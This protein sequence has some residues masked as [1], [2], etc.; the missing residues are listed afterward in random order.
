L[1]LAD[2]RFLADANVDPEVVLALSNRGVD[3]V[4]MLDIGPADFP[5]E[6]VLRLAT[7][8][9]RVLITHD[10][11]FGELTVAQGEPFMGIVFLRPGHMIAA[12]TLGTIDAVWRETA[13]L[14][15]Q[16]ILVARRTDDNVAIRVRYVRG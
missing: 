8:Q 7:A 12:F 11:D 15:E 13:E 3:V 5:V 9:G 14:R 1:R 2:C 10:S 4:S 6:Q 16:F